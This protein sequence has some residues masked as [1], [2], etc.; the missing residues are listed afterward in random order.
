MPISCECPSCGKRLK[1]PDSA[2]GKRAKC[3]QCGNP[4][5][6]PAEKIYDAEEVSD[7]ADDPSAADSAGEYSDNEYGLE[8]R[9]TEDQDESPAEDDR[10]PCPMCGEMIAPAAV[11]CRFCGEVFDQ[12]VK[13]KMELKKKGL[14][15]E[16]A[17]L[18]SADWVLGIV[19]A[20]IGCIMSI[21]YIIQGKPKGMKMLGVSLLGQL[22]WFVVGIIIE[23]LKSQ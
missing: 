1:A 5:E 14:T 12:K 6:I 19:C 21:V 13:R 20:N 22:C 3:P 7:S 11:K 9:E 2:A 16:D 8:R 10:R 4:V 18:S 15:E 17:N 23:V